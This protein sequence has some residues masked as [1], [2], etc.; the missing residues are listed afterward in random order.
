M[1]GMI[2][3]TRPELAGQPS[4]FMLLERAVEQEY[5]PLMLADLQRKVYPPL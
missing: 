4:Q 1:K 2:T 3:P 5:R